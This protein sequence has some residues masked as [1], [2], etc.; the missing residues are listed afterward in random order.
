MV[1]KG[2]NFLYVVG[3]QLLSMWKEQK[4]DPNVTPHTKVN[5]K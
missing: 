2:L 1:R 5:S 4:L 3:E